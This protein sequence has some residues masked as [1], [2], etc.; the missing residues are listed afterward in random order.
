[1]KISNFFC[2]KYSVHSIRMREGPI[3]LLEI[4]SCWAAKQNCK[5]IHWLCWTIASYISSTWLGWLHSRDCKMKQE[6][7]KKFF[8]WSESSNFSSSSLFLF[9]PKTS[10][11]QKKKIE[12]NSS[13]E[14]L[15]SSFFFLLFDFLSFRPFSPFSFL[16]RLRMLAKAVQAQEIPKARLDFVVDSNF[17]IAD[18]DGRRVALRQVRDAYFRILKQATVLLFEELMFGI[19]VTKVIGTERGT[20]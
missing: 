12:T 1:M 16:A 6:S 20:K 19:E 4:S 5:I 14:I 3:T 2:A 7:D 18:I 17:L 8:K 13:I 9:L 11:S 15:P 10:S